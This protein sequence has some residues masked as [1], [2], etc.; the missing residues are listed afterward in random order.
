MTTPYDDRRHAA[1]SAHRA[2]TTDGDR[3]RA[4]RD[5]AGATSAQTV[6]RE[7]ILEH[8]HDAVG[9]LRRAAEDERDRVVVAAFERVVAV[10]PSR[11]SPAEYAS[12]IDLDAH[13]AAEERVAA[14]QRLSSAVAALDARL[15]RPEVPSFDDALAEDPS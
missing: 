5:Y 4:R 6:E 2:A 9:R 7:R 14:L 13:W 1:V 10:G 11:L 15:R 8:V 3:L 12:L